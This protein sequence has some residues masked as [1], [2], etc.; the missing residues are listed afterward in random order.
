MPNNVRLPLCVMFNLEVISCDECSSAF[1]VMA[2]LEYEL[3][4]DDQ[5]KFVDAIEIANIIFNRS[6]DG[7]RCVGV[8]SRHQL[9]GE[10]MTENRV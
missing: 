7:G 10:S 8:A 3:Q 4:F 5:V 9:L 2:D 1:V 6:F